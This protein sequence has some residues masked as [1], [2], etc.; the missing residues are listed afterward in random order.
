MR[1]WLHLVVY[2]CFSGIVSA[3]NLVINPSFET[4]TQ[5]PWLTSQILLCPPWSNVAL[6]QGTV[7]YFHFCATGNTLSGVPANTLGHQWPATGD[8][9]VGM[10]PKGPEFLAGSLVSAL[11]AGR[12]YRVSLKCSMADI[13]YVPG[14]TLAPDSLVTNALGIYLGASIPP[15]PG[16]AVIPVPFQYQPV[17]TVNRHG[18]V[19]IGFDYVATGGEQYILI[20]NFL[21][22]AAMGGENSSVLYFY[23]DDVS[24]EPLDNISIWGTLELCIGQSGI[25]YA[26]DENGTNVFVLWAT[27]TDPGTVIGH[28]SSLT[29]NPSVTTT[30]YAYNG[31]D[32]ATWT[33]L[34][35]PYPSVDLGPD[36][37]ACG[38][39]ISLVLAV[40]PG[41]SP[42][43]TYYEWPDYST[44]TTFTVTQTGVYY[45]TAGL[46]GCLAFDTVRVTVHPVPDTDLGGDRS[47]CPGETVT[48]DAAAP[49][50]TYLWQDQSVGPTYT[51]NAGGV[52]HVRATIGGCSASDTVTVTE[53]PNP[54]F[55]L[56]GRVT[57][58]VGTPVTLD[59]TVPGA[60]YE[61]NGGAATST[62]SPSQS[63]RFRVK[64]TLGPCSVTDSVDVTFNPLPSVHIAGNS[65]KPCTGTT[66]VLDAT[67]PGLAYRWPDGSTLPTYT[68][69]Q[70]GTY[71]VEVTD[72]AGCRNTATTTVTYLAPPLFV[73]TDSV[74]CYGDT[75][76]LDITAQDAVYLW[77][78][79]SVSPV[80]TVTQAGTY[81]GMAA[82]ACGSH[83][84]TVEIGYRRCNCGFY[85][86]DSFT[87]DRDGQNEIF[88][89][90]SNEECPLTDYTFTVFN[91]WGGVIFETGNPEYGWDGTV[92]GRPAPLGVY[93]YRL[94]YKFDKTP[95]STRLGSIILI[96]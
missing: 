22:N 83:A 71:A 96:R 31:P 25:I 68:V 92:K 14:D 9:Y 23:I 93:V 61:W 5:C 91:R 53:F 21:G 42:A 59:A 78:D 63:G 6:H 66:V 51:V 2:L 64:V 32:T 69:T 10:G 62:I 58:C 16:Y 49:G 15:T 77:Q 72:T 1:K 29:V 54:V 37:E 18:W 65:T 81:W 36:R 47:L 76:G 35:K 50:A 73:F 12:T 27:A 95:L 7:D 28:G 26:L 85:V 46:N 39:D 30:Y 17:F 13:S 38:G 19:Q 75:W 82:N 88:T 11:V 57:G 67:Q 34:V 24:V 55:D 43:G 45:V 56:G 89:P 79:K 74:L 90:V 52:Y 87:P 8:A 48:L 80:F 70:S 84:D 94:L 41:T 60:T 33:V 20:G 3:Q 44:G 40:D 4:H 86:P